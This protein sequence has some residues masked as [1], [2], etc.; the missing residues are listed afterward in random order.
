MQPGQLSRFG[1]KQKLAFVR[2]C[3]AL[4][5]HC[6]S[7]AGPI[8][9]PRIVLRLRRRPLAAA[10]HLV[11]TLKE[12]KAFAVARANSSAVTKIGLGIAT[13]DGPT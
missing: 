1:H 9:V 5:P 8:P 11:I 10:I 3:E 7:K 2:A 12:I 4:P 13:V 6:D